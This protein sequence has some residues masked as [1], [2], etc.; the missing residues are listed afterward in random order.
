[1]S[2]VTDL[3]RS[4]SRGSSAQ[5]GQ[6][7][8]RDAA[9]LSDPFSAHRGQI[10]NY[11]ASLF[12]NGQTPSYFTPGQGM[13]MGA[14]IQGMAGQGIN[15]GQ[16]LTDMATQGLPVGGQGLPVAGQGLPVAGQGLPVAGQGLPVAGQ[17]IPIAGQG[18]ANAS[19]LNPTS[20]DIQNDPVRA[21]QMRSMTNA[22]QNSAAASGTLDSGGTLAALQQNASDIT[23][24]AGD[25]LY[26]RNANTFGLQNQ[27]QNQAFG[28]GLSAQGQSFNQGFNNQ[29]TAFNQ[30]F[31]TQGAN[32]GQ[33]MAAQQQ[34]YAQRLGSQGQGFA[35][36]LAAL[37]FGNNAQNQGFAQNLAAGGFTNAAQGQ[38]NQQ[39]N[40]YLNFLAGL[41]GA[42]PQNAAVAGSNIVQGFNAGTAAQGSQN[43]S[44]LGSNG[45]LF[46]TIGN[47]GSWLLTPSDA[48]LKEDVKHIGE[49]HAG[50]PIYSYKYKWGGPKTMGVMAQDVEKVDPDAVTTH[51]SGF[52]LVN[53]GK[54][55]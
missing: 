51:A 26:A 36:T 32:F 27:A 16:T 43:Q 41:A 29:N 39:G 25:R 55:H 40:Q 49:T 19:L 14:G 8:G 37:G 24:N 20:A 6:Q 28:Q 11:L 54:V 5:S 50:L 42:T 18:M 46:G 23:A 30:G 12:A 48:R 21:A 7:S 17:G 31:A 34:D 3:F 15:N 38:M 35:Q 2:F 44:M 13:N 33:G 47:I 52:K 10:G 4:N 9:A 45:S 53:Y 22:V 1:M